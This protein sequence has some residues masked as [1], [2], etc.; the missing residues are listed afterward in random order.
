MASETIL[1][2]VFNRAVRFSDFEFGSVFGLVRSK[3]TT[4]GSVIGIL[5]REEWIRKYGKKFGKKSG[6]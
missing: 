2:P 4:S 6:G 5:P 3:K 1:A